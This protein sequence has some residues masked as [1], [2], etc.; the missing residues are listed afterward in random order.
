LSATTAAPPTQER[1][2]TAEEFF[3]MCNAEGKRE[4]VRGRVNKMSPA[5]EAHGEVAMDVGGALWQH[6]RKAQTGRV[7]AAETGFILSHDPDTIRAPDAAFVMEERIPVERSRG[8]FDGAPDIAV[9]IISPSE[10]PS[11][12]EAKIREY[13][14]AG[15]RL[16]WV[17]YPDIRTVRVYRPDGT[18]EVI[19]ENGTLSG[20]DVLP[21]FELPL[22]DVFH[23]AR[24]QI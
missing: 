18:T 22:S 23:E 14:A 24:Q 9:E 10:T 7:F 1:L 16:L 20:E 15:T 12:V 19:D 4:L 2:V 11:E 3:R 5:G 21:D 17:V 13:L 6:V 8:F